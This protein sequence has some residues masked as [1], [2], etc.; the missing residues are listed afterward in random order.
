MIFFLQYRL[1][2]STKGYQWEFQKKFGKYNSRRESAFPFD[3]SFKE[4]MEVKKY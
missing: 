2:Q 1:H 4:K 3:V